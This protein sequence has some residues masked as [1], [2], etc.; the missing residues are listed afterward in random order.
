MTD[1]DSSLPI[2]T[3]ADGDVVSKICDATT[4]TQQLEVDSNGKIGINNT[5]FLAK[6][7]EGD[8]YEVHL[9]DTGSGDEICE[10]DTQEGLAVNTPKTFTYIV[11]ADRT[12]YLHEIYASGSG[13]IKV[14]VKT[15]V[16]GSEETRWVGFNSTSNPVCR[17]KIN[18]PIVEVTGHKVLVIVTNRDNQAQ[19]VYYTLIGLEKA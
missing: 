8:V 13:K 19:D 5:E 16:S 10:Y 2:R 17:F 1:Y 7:D 12:L 15:G 11:S 18:I 14:E 6:Q 4:N 3:E 9:S